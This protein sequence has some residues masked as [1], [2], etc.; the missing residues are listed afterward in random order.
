MEAVS[1]RKYRR[2]NIAQTQDMQRRI[3]C[4]TA[5]QWFYSV[6]NFVVVTR[7]ITII[8]SFSSPIFVV[9]VF[10]SSLFVYLSGCE[11]L[12]G[13]VFIQPSFA[14]HQSSRRLAMV[15]ALTSI[16]L[17][18]CR[19]VTPDSLAALVRSFLFMFRFSNDYIHWNIIMCF[20]KKTSWP[21]YFRKYG[22]WGA[23]S[24]MAQSS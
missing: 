14:T 5:T 4:Y 9:V 18:R 2:L 8:S 22:W 10:P 23:E 6:R 11:G 1:F 20:E 19:G 16:S 7:V 13:Q 15:S 24:T 3:S 21:E 12:D 17:A